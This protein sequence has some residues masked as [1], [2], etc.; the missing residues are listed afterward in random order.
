MPLT[1]EQVSSEGGRTRPF[2]AERRVVFRRADD[3]LVAEVTLVRLDAQAE[4]EIVRNYRLATGGL[5]DHP[6]RFRLMDGRITAVDDADA[7]WAA[8]LAPFKRI[9]PPSDRSIPD[10]A[11]PGAALAALPPQRRTAMLAGALQPL[12]GN[13]DASLEEGTRR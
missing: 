3:G 2:V 12:L 9:V 11:R 6:V 13:V 1:T 8:F 7:T 5:L 4:A 10:T